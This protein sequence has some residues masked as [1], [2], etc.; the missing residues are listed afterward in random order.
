MI[1]TAKRHC[2]IVRFDAFEDVGGEQ[3]FSLAL[4]DDRGDGAVLSSIVGRREHRVFGKPL[5][6]GTSPYGLSAE[7][8]RAI[9]SAYSAKAAKE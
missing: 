8:T 7:E 4:Y 1:A 6:K 3:S 2:G 9:E 5:T